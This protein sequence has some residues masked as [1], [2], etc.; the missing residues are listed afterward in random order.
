MVAKL[1]KLYFK[2]KVGQT[3]W[4]SHA[5]QIRNVGFHVRISSDTKFEVEDKNTSTSTNEM[6]TKTPLVLKS[7]H[8]YSR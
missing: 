8:V 6:I 5:D 2:I 7:G 3:I 1:G 4:K